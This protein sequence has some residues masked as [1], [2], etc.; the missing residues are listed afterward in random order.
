MRIDEAN[1]VLAEVA[2]GGVALEV[3]KLLG[4][5]S[6]LTESIRFQT[7]E[8]VERRLVVRRPTEYLRTLD[9]GG[10]EREWTMLGLAQHGGIAVP[11][12][13]HF[14]ARGELLGEPCMIVEHIDGEAIFAVDD[15]VSYGRQM[16]LA[17]AGVHA[18]PAAELVNLRSINAPSPMSREETD[19]VLAAARARVL[20]WENWG[21][22]RLAVLHGDFWP[23]NLL[24]RDGRL[25]AIIDWE[26]ACLGDPLSDVAISRLD[27]LWLFGD[28]AVASFTEAYGS[29]CAIDPER[30]ALWDLRAALRPG[31]QLPMWAGAYADKGRA[32]VTAEHMRI[33]Q[34]RFAADALERART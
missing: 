10:L 1:R 13:I 23:G 21:N 32:D 19:E 26:D 3:T 12:R 4:G 8:G 34:L 2:P 29:R 31:T 20:A 24:W 17:L 15:V 5:V 27:L 28:E 7:T 16:G 22:E 33:K 14:D 6:A 9:P 30:L 18:L 25:V 11:E